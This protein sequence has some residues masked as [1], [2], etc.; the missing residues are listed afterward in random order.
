[1]APRELPSTAEPLIK[2]RELYM[3]WLGMIKCAVGV[4]LSMMKLFPG[5]FVRET[6]AAFQPRPSTLYDELFT[7][8]ASCEEMFSD[9]FPVPGS[10]SI[11][12]FH[13]SVDTHMPVH[14]SYV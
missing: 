8:Q 13:D 9:Q 5:S 7:T 1:M 6:P 14:S 3:L 2:A 12:I 4:V 11:S 10:A